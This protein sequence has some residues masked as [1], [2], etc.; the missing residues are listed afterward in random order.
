[1]RTDDRIIY[2]LTWHSA[3][4]SNIYQ[5]LSE[6]GDIMHHQLLSVCQMQCIVKYIV[7]FIILHN[8]CSPHL[9]GSLA[10]FLSSAKLSAWQWSMWWSFVCSPMGLLI[11]ATTCCLQ[12]RRSCFVV[13]QKQ[14]C[15]ALATSLNILGSY[16]VWHYFTENCSSNYEMQQTQRHVAW[17]CIHVGMQTICIGGNIND[18]C[19]L[20][21]TYR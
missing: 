9:N 2:M 7:H 11:T 1:M 20:W 21:C 3:L 12:S 18:R 5:M 16:L 8:S 19:C 10:W 4:V 13:L 6:W 15:I 14:N 17:P